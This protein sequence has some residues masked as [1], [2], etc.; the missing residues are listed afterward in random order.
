MSVGVCVRVWG[1]VVKHNCE[2]IGG[3]VGHATES[4]S[5]K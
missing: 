5:N 4:I 3:K 1:G 2:N